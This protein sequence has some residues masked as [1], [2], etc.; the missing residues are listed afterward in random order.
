MDSVYVKELVGIKEGELITVK[1]SCTGFTHDDLL[2]S[3]VIL[4]RCVLDSKE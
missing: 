4:N 2:G 3:D 1:G